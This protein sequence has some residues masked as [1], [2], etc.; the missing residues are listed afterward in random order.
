M[1]IKDLKKGTNKDLTGFTTPENDVP[2]GTG[3][4]NI[5]AIIK[6]EK[7]LV[8]SIILLKMKAAMLLSR[9]RKVFYILKV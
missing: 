4:L 2:V 3:E 7:K 5:P 9:N 1:H 8:S 6:A